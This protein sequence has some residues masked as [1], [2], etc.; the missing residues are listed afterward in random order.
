MSAI[1]DMYEK[2]RGHYESVPHGEEYDKCLEELVKCDDE[3]REAL[4]ENPKLLQLYKKT[5]DALDALSIVCEDEHY[6][7]GFKFG[8]LMGLDIAGM[9]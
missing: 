3:M 9:R 1:R 8:V 7:E 4:K 6:I 2:R 5:T